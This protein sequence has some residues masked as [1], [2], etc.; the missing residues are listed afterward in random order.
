MTTTTIILDDRLSSLT[1]MAK[2]ARSYMTGDAIVNTQQHVDSFKS[3]SNQMAM[4]KLMSSSSSSSS[5]G[6]NG[7]RTA[8]VDKGRCRRSSD[9]LE[10]YRVDQSN[11][12][13]GNDP[14]AIIEQYLY[15]RNYLKAMLVYDKLVDFVMQMCSAASN[16]DVAT[17]P[18]HDFQYAEARSLCYY[19]LF[20][21]TRAI[22]SLDE[23]LLFA[24]CR[25]S[26][27]GGD[28]GGLMT[29]NSGTATAIRET[30]EMRARLSRDKLDMVN[31]TDTELKSTLEE[32]IYNPTLN[33]SNLLNETFV[34]LVHERQM[35]DLFITAVAEW[36]DITTTT[37]PQLIDEEESIYNTT[38]ISI[39][40]ACPELRNLL[41]TL[42][43]P[44]RCLSKSG[45]DNTPIMDVIGS[46][47]LGLSPAHLTALEEIIQFSDY[48]NLT[49]AAD[50]LAVMAVRER[51]LNSCQE[52]YT[53]LAQSL[54]QTTGQ[55]PDRDYALTLG[56]FLILHWGRLVNFLVYYELMRTCHPLQCSSIQIGVVDDPTT[57]TDMIHNNKRYLSKHTI[58]YTN[59]RYY[60]CL[61]TSSAGFQSSSYKLLYAE[62]IRL[63]RK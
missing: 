13:T 23:H 61:P 12:L 37:T 1:N 63:L 5:G 36:P 62:I 55:L 17:S 44:K 35:Y 56:R 20:L 29:T 15:D 60:Y 25:A 41:L 48:V 58:Y 39:C 53:T 54:T 2:H 16:L 10:Q 45:M 50:I 6:G 9:R 11:Y 43:L 34:L 22:L 42:G 38:K 3:Y 4:N 7:S 33:L 51:E 14:D 40:Y 32:T 18:R 46:V 30:C 27:P 26:A 19:S 28:V 59:G 52:E 31:A 8:G 49:S 24:Y 47:L 57:P 21:N